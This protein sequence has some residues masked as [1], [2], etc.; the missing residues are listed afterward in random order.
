MAIIR[1][2]VVEHYTSRGVQGVL[3]NVG[4]QSALTDVNGYF[5][6]VNVPLGSY[7]MQVVHRDFSPYTTPVNVP[8][9][10]VYTVMKSIKIQSVVRPL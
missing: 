10:Q 5:T 1:G 7:S 6:V 3:V 9:N 4:G 2:R 8:K